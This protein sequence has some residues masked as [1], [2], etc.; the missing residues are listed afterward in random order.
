MWLITYVADETIV[1]YIKI[2]V[3]YRDMQLEIN[4]ETSTKIAEVSDILGIKKAEL[5]ERAIL[6]Y[7]DNLSKYLDLKKELSEWDTL[8][9]EAWDNFE[10]KL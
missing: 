4:K 2:I 9:E 5:V 8:S 7:L 10:K 1:N 3:L 6:I